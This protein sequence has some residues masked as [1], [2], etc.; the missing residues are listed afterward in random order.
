MLEV[1]ARLIAGGE[2]KISGEI[3]SGLLPP[4]CRDPGGG[5]SGTSYCIRGAGPPRGICRARSDRPASLRD[6]YSAGDI[7]IEQWIIHEMFHLRNRRD[8][9]YDRFITLAFPD[10]SDPLVQWI[11]KDPYHS[12]FAPEEAFI[13]LITF[14]DPA[15][16]DAQKKVVR[17]WYDQ[18]GAQERSLEE[19]RGILRV[20]RH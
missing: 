3:L 5:R 20:V 2:D 4:R 17:Q 9:E 10:E 15:R 8:H 1:A 12:T 11:K 7:S 6:L 13:N 14:A 18:I 19:I 16:T